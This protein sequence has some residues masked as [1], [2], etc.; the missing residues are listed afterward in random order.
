MRLYVPI[1]AKEFEQLRSLAYAER[2]RPQDQAALILAAQLE[3]ATT[4]GTSQ[5]VSE[6]NNA[7]RLA[8][9]TR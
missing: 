5:H 4:E 6:P 8:E 9:T 2:R 7:E 3:R 1:S